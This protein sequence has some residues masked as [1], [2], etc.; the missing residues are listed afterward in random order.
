MVDARTLVL[1]YPPGTN[2]LWRNVRGKTLLSAEARAFKTKAGLLARAA[3]MRPRAGP[4]L[5]RVDLF[6][7]R[8][9]GDIDNPLKIILDSLEG[10][11]Y[12]NDKQV[13]GLYVTRHDDS[14]NP[15][16]QVVVEDAVQPL[17]TASTPATP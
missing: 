16:V 14:G 3:G 7:P 10:H 17:A 15:R 13:V 4:V 8:R 9:I 2:R 1:P 5:V 12:E 11:A 6:R